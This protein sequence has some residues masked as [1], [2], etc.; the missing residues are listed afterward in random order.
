MD[1]TPTLAGFIVF[2][3]SVVGIPTAVMAD[4]DAGF[5]QA[6]DFSL[7]WIPVVPLT[8]I[9]PVLY[10]SAVYNWAAS[11]LIQYQPDPTGQV[12]FTNARSSFGVSNFMAGV[13]SSASN[14]A[15]SQSMTVGKGLQNLSLIDL[16]RVKDP[17]GRQALAILQQLGTLWGLS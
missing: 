10:T 14:E 8:A 9:S 7:E 5:Q 16:Q 3:R 4:D 2:C 1:I 13:I 17:Y 15:T 11:N 6:L 12:F